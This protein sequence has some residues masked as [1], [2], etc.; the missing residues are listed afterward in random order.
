SIA[1]LSSKEK[2]KIN[3]IERD[4]GIEF[5]QVKIASAEEIVYQRIENWCQEI[6]SKKFKKK[7]DPRAYEVASLL[8]GNLSKEE[9]IAKVIMNEVEKMT[10]KTTENLNDSRKDHPRKFRD[11]DR[12]RKRKHSRPDRKFHKKKFKKHREKK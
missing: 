4:L 5:E 7:L 3:R 8:F 9:L 10:V 1:F 11:R 2:H 12:D 6:L